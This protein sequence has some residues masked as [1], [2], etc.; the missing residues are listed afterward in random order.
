MNFL[1]SRK[2]K[3]N[4][5]FKNNILIENYKKTIEFLNYPLMQKERNEGRTEGR[6]KVKNKGRQKR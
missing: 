3:E 6:K 1:E 4:Y 2:F 5:E